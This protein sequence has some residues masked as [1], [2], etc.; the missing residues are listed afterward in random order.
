MPEF[1]ALV[2]CSANV[3]RS[4]SAAA[5]LRH[6]LTGPDY[7]GLRITDA[8][9]RTSS[10]Q[11]WCG[12]AVAHLQQQ[13]ILTGDLPDHPA[14]QVGAADLSEAGLVLA[15]DRAVLGRLIRMDPTVRDRLF[16]IT[17]VAALGPPIAAERPTY[18][19]STD[20][21]DISG[22]LSWWVGAMD[23]ARGLVDMTESAE[24]RFR[25]PRRAV[26][27][28]YDVPDAHVEANGVSHRRMLPLLVEAVD[29]IAATVRSLV[30]SSSSS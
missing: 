6:R 27:E 22:V 28:G 20:G 11:S 1:T 13:R 12:E 3:C 23:D 16:T 14:R 18:V 25:W 9:V 5:V 21:G 8:G 7:R 26:V 24:R 30:R 17:E 2:V 15:A 4:P 19:V 10:G 29:G